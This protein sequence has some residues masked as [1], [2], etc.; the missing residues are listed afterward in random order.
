MTREADRV[1]AKVA[2]VEKESMPFTLVSTAGFHCDVRRSIGVMVRGGERASMDFMLK[3][4]K[5]PCTLAEIRVSG[6]EYLTIKGALEEIVPT[7]RFGKTRMDA[8]PSVV[9]L[10]VNCTPRFDLSSPGNKDEALA[11]LSRRGSAK[12]QLADFVRRALYWTDEESKIIDLG[13]HREPGPGQRLRGRYLDGFHVF[14]Y[15]DMLDV[16]EEVDDSL[17]FRFQVCIRRLDYLQ[18]LVKQLQ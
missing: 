2:C 16:I 13:G 3:R 10:A 7:A 8:K 17:S 6:K 12:A 14:F 4:Y 9:V 15:L 1:P 18:R 11:L 5:R